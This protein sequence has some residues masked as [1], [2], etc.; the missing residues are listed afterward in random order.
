MRILKNIL[1]LSP[2]QELS[3][4]QGFFEMGMDSLMAVE[5]R[6]RIQMAIGSEY[7]LSNTLMFEQNNIQ[8]LAE[9][10]STQV[11]FEVF[12][13]SKKEKSIILYQALKPEE[14]I[15]IV[16]MACRFPGGAN[17]PDTFWELLAK[18]YDGISEVPNDRWDI[19]EYYDPD[20]NAPGKM[21]TRKGGFLTIDVAQFDAAFF[22]ISPEKRRRWIHN[23]A[24][25]WK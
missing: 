20:P 4:T 12:E 25:Y 17:S 9:Y 8:A 19:N 1:G 23:N 24:C 13:R 6:N 16:G 7:A 15:A 5:L 22:N 2:T 14:P 10:L 18:G 11:L 21:N 3:D